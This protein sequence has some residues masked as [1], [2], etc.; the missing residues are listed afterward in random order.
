[1]GILS[2]SDN[3]LGRKKNPTGMDEDLQLHCLLLSPHLREAGAREPA[4]CWWLQWEELEGYRGGEGRDSCCWQQGWMSFKLKALHGGLGHFCSCVAA[5][6]I[7]PLAVQHSAL[8]LAERE[9]NKEISKGKMLGFMFPC[10]WE[11]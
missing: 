10:K 8:S 4:S 2:R 7:E 11:G 3:C 6:H 9:S 5:P 1:M